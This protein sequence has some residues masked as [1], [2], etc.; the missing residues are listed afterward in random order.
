MALDKA[1][2]MA[3]IVEPL[4]GKTIPTLWCNNKAE[5]KIANNAASMKKTKNINCEFHLTNEHLQK[6]TILLEWIP[7]VEQ[8]ADCFTKALGASLVRRFNE[9]V[10]GGM[11]G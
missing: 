8:L 1:I 11:E 2:W 10:Y 4:I 3:G 6:G 9:T 7:G 5:V